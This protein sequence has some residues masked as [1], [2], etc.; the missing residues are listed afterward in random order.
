MNNSGVNQ[1]L[2]FSRMRIPFLLVLLISS[3]S[4]STSAQDTTDYPA[5]R[6]VVQRLFDGMRAGDSALVRSAFT[7]DAVM[8]TTYSDKKGTPYVETGTLNDFLDAVGT[9]HDEMWDERIHDVEIRTDDGLAQVWAPYVFYLDKNKLHCG[10]N[11]FQL[12]RTTDGW[13][14]QALTDSRRREPCE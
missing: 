1:K 9:P 10:V 5:V 6:A 8:F 13:K 12:V 4:F 3:A 11:A 7:A 14:I 2:T